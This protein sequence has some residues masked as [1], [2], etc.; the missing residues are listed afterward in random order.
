MMHHLKMRHMVPLLFV[1]IVTASFQGTTLLRGKQ[2]KI[3]Y[4][5]TDLWVT[6]SSEPDE[7]LLKEE[8][9]LSL[10]TRTAI[11]TYTDRRTTDCTAHKATQEVYPKSF[12]LNMHC[13]AWSHHERRTSESGE[14]LTQTF[15]EVYAP[16]KKSSYQDFASYQHPA[17]ILCNHSLLIWRRHRYKR[18]IVREG[19]KMN[20]LVEL[21]DNSG[22][23]V[24]GDPSFPKTAPQPKDDLRSSFSHF[25]KSNHQACSTATLLKV[26]AQ[27]KHPITTWSKCSPKK[28]TLFEPR[29]QSKETYNYNGHQRR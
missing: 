15:A 13:K 12:V 8:S 26:A 23:C 18:A 1:T 10:R 6:T 27:T 7:N 24:K 4:G 28:G 16:T 11:R 20:N 29:W 21:M 14:R 3:N 22:F 25:T 17:T 19:E 9:W 2:T 5:C